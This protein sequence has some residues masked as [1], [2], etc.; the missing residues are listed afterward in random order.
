MRERHQWKRASDA[1]FIYEDI[2]KDG[3]HFT[4]VT[5]YLNLRNK[6]TLRA[7]QGRAGLPHTLHH[8]NV[9][10]SVLQTEVLHVV[11]FLAL[12]NYKAALL[13][14]NVRC[15]EVEEVINKKEYLLV[16]FI[17]TKLQVC[18]VFF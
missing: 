12:G 11:L 10:I 3:L 2:K 5:F 17:D 6:A 8:R 7:G 15:I 9:G 1:H 18:K 14:V 13:K 16:L 4:S